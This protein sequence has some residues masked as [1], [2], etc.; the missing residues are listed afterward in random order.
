MSLFCHFPQVYPFTQ[1]IIYVTDQCLIK[2]VLTSAVST[3]LVLKSIYYKWHISLNMQQELAEQ[4][5]RRH[6]ENEYERTRKEAL[7]RMKQA[8]EQRKAEEL[9]RAEELRKQMEE[10]KLREQE[11]FRESIAI[12]AVLDIMSVISLSDD[13][14]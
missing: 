4:E 7:E 1:L 5:E 9:K 8:E 3:I 11:V 10:L 6:F 12:V 13:P 2:K 14:S